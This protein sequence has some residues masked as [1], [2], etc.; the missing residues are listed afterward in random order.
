MDPI[1]ELQARR[2]ALERELVRVRE[3]VEVSLEGLREELRA[4]LDWRRW[5]R[6]WPVGSLLLTGVLGFWLSSALGRGGRARS[7]GGIGQMILRQL[8]GALTDSLASWLRKQVTDR[9]LSRSENR[10]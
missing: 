6:R 7:S 3:D 9:L 10:R 4:G 5:V 8:I 2:R 1:E